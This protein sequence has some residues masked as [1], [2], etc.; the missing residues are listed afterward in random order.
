VSSFTVGAGRVE[1]RRTTSSRRGSAHRR[2]AVPKAQF[3]YNI[4]QDGKERSKRRV[5]SGDRAVTIRKP[6]GIV[7]EE[8]GDGMV[9]VASVDPNGNAGKTGQVQVGDIVVA[10]SA[11]F[12]D[13]VWSTR[14]VGLGKI[15]KSISVRQ[16]SNVTL[17]LESPQQVAEKK[18]SAADTAMNRRAEARDRFGERQVLDPSTWGTIQGGKQKSPYSDDGNFTP[19]ETPT[20]EGYKEVATPE[21]YVPNISEEELKRQLAEE[22]AST[23]LKKDNTVLYGSIASAVGLVLLIFLLSR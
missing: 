3:N 5:S 2:V 1:V 12:G 11:T 6:L 17:V 4:Y 7:L 8:A 21:K 18:Q 22:S 23:P 10:C 16:G 9:F 15:M 19:G 14:G 20:F 13:E